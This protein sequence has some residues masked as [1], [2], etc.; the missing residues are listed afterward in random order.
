M[1]CDIGG[2][3]VDITVQLKLDDQHTEVVIP[4]TGNDNGG[5]KINDAFLKLLEKIVQDPNFSRFVSV[6]LFHKAIVAEIGYVQFEQEKVDFCNTEG[7]DASGTDDTL[8]V[9]L[10]S[11]FGNFYE[12]DITGGLTKL[13]DPMIEFDTDYT[14]T[15]MIKR[16]R[17]VKLLQPVIEGVIKSALQALQKVAWKIDAIYLVGG[18]GGCKYTYGKLKE[19]IEHNLPANEQMIP[20]IVPKYHISAVAEGAVMYRQHPENIQSRVIDATYGIGISVSFKEGEHDEYYAYND[21][22]NGKKM[23]N[24]IFKTFIKTGDKVAL[25][26]KRET[27]VIPHKQ[28]NT[29]STIRFY[30]TT[31]TDVK[32][33]KDKSGKLNVTEIGSLILDIP[34]DENLPKNERKILITM[35][36]S[37]TEIQA[38]SRAVYIPDS[39]SVKVQLDFLSI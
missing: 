31:S 24:N 22:D 38:E 8:N 4:P 23:C 33:V 26:D 25:F 34:N 2:G 37:G 36:F 20:I 9:F 10:Q 6:E 17:V 39:P 27:T 15:I 32:Y 18:F 19:A 14:Y 1:V 11:E 30:S 21:P 7:F 29:K 35:D 12:K 3:T 5:R 28:S 13:N 16:S